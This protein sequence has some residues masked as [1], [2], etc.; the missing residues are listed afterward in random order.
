MISQN[1]KFKF[2]SV[3]ELIFSL[4]SINDFKQFLKDNR[5]GLVLTLDGINL[6]DKEYIEY[7]LLKADKSVKSIN[8]KDLPD[9]FCPKAC[10]LVDEFHRKTA[11]E[12][13]EWMLYFDYSTGDVIYCWKGKE[14]TTGGLYDK[15]NFQ[16]RRIASLHNHSKDYYSFPS[17]DNFDILENEFEDYEIITSLKCFWIVGF[18]GSV[19]NEYRKDFQYRIAKD[20]NTI[21]Y[22]IKS[23][24]TDK[25]IINTMMEFVIG[26]YLLNS[27]DKKINNN[28]LYL[29][30]KEV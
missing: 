30:K 15:F 22:K 26:E 25:N 18:K 16:D 29:I 14:D 11:N 12:D 27:F 19:G 24:Y 3:I 6:P 2:L 7:K 13:I 4:F 8:P 17:P 5:G 1:L 10:E 23:K 21:N 20:M 28:C 9:D